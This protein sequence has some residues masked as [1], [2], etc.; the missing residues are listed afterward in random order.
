MLSKATP[1]GSVAKFAAAGKRTKK[2]DLGMMAMSYGYVYVAKV[3]MGANPAQLL[4]AMVE[5]EAYKGP[6]LIIAY[7]P[8][9]NHG[10]K[11][12]M[13]KVQDEA[14]R[15]V[16]AGYWPLYRYNPD[17]AAQG[18]NPFTLDS[19]PATGD[20]KEFILGENRYA[21]LKQQFPEEAATLF[22]RAEQE[23]KDKY[24]YYKKLNDME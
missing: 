24:D 12:G 1:T 14:K 13:S 9:I 19:K 2:K 4:K 10:I 22:A 21:A 16:E 20:Y 11:A 23:A 18:K 6:S 7:A 17:L 15:A 8:C 3:C 5:A